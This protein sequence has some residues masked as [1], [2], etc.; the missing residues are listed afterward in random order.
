[1]ASLIHGHVLNFAVSQLRV[2][3]G[4]SSDILRTTECEI[5]L[6]FRLKKITVFGP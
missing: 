6:T 5:I 2:R 4:M 1:M 3:L